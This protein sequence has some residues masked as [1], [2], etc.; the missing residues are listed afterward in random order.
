MCIRDSIFYNDLVLGTK[1][2]SDGLKAKTRCFFNTLRVGLVMSTFRM[3]AEWVQGVLRGECEGEC[4]E[5]LEMSQLEMRSIR[6]E[7]WVINVWSRH[8]YNSFLWFCLNVTE[9]WKKYSSTKLLNLRHAPRMERTG[10]LCRCKIP[11]L[12]V[13]FFM[14]R[15]GCDCI[16]NC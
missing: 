8:R 1:L 11:Y 10:R 9:A 2:S 3:S 15:M 7:L 6:N 12:K 14:G 5:K 13:G 16:N 4:G